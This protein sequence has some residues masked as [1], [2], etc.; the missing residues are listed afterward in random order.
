MLYDG[1][2]ANNN[3]A[4]SYSVLYDG[5]S[6][7]NNWARSGMVYMSYN[8]SR[9]VLMNAFVDNFSTAPA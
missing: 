3:W 8:C 9:L 4:R 6:A 2:S 5:S 1:S 7:N